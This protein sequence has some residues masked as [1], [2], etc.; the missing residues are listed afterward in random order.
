M[1]RLETAIMVRGIGLSLSVLCM[2]GSLAAAGETS[3]YLG[4]NRRTGT[5]EAEI[6]SDPVL[7]W[8]YHERHRPRH[9]WAEPNREVQYIDFDYATQ[10]AIAGGAVFFGSSADHKLGALTSEV[11]RSG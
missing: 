10:T 1:R 6:P 5:V 4:D 11:Q 8:V 9:A 7:Q 2:W 3:T